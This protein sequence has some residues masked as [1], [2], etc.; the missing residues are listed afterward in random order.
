MKFHHRYNPP[1]HQGVDFGDEPS[2]TK[3]AHKEECDINNIV[4]KALRNGVLPNAP[5]NPQ[6]ADL[7]EAVDYREAI[8]VVQRAQEQFAQL[9]ALTRAR[10]G[11]DPAAFLQFASDPSNG[12]E[13][14]RM[15]LATRVEDPEAPAPQPTQPR[16]AQA[17]KKGNP[18]PKG[19]S[20][21]QKS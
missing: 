15:G 7:S 1:T 2:R 16:A 20:D 3:Q 17:P 21:D 14:V 4:K 10:F 12:A 11:N 6:Y 18:A 13:M 5:P 8:H 19:D 9:P